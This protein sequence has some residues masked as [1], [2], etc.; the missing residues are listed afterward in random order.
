MKR[1]PVAFLCLA[2][3][4]GACAGGADQAYSRQALGP[5]AD[6]SAGRTIAVVRCSR[7]HGLDGISRT[8][9]PSAPA[10]AELMDRYT[11][12]MLAADLV[13]GIRIGHDDMPEFSLPKADAE[14]LVAYLES[15]R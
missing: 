15:L 5:E 8:P 4:L 10:L 13:D 6:I 11:P 1:I 7:C 2:S 3:M 9:H 12:H 14:S